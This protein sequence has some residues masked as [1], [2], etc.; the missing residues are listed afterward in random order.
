MTKEGKSPRSNIYFRQTPKE[1]RSAKQAEVYEHIQMNIPYRILNFTKDKLT[2]AFT[3]V[4]GHIKRFV[5]HLP[6]DAKRIKA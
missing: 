5:M 3:Q 2:S 6:K 4:H 1:F